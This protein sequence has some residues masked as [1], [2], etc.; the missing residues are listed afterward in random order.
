MD[1]NKIMIYYVILYYIILYYIER[2]CKEWRYVLIKNGVNNTKAWAR[3]G[4]QVISELDEDN[5]GVKST[6]LTFICL[7]YG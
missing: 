7:F 4:S 1:L 5:V 3:C 2:V 6:D